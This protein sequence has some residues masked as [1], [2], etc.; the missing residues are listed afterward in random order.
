MNR[1]MIGGIIV[2]VV[3][4][5]IAGVFLLIE[6]PD[7]E[8]KTVFNPPLED[9]MQKVKDDLAAQKPQ[10][11]KLVVDAVKPPPGESHETG[12]WHDGHWHRTAL[13]TDLPQKLPV[14]VT[15]S[16]KTE[17]V[18]F[19]EVKG[20]N[21]PPPGHGYEFDESGKAT[22][23]KYNKPRFKTGWSEKFFPGQ[24][25]HK[26]SHDE[27]QLYH[28]LQHIVSGT[29]LRLDSDMIRLVKSGHPLPKAIYNQG[30]VEL[31]RVLKAELAEKA[32]GPNPRVGTDITWD[33]PFTP[34]ELAAI[35][36][37]EN[38]LLKSMRSPERPTPEWSHLVDTVIKD[39]EEDQRK[40]R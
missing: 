26:L 27:W 3:L 28:V 12:Y 18:K 32:S 29:V 31:A 2:L 22:L 21:A 15:E 38:E 40:R 37:Q 23:F 39:L 4:L 10:T 36:R 17:L 35:E 20:L 6:K 7:T 33:R 13:S 14:Y 8:P 9:D 11:E 25:F 16:D 24:D 19:W 30:V 1:N 34:E 5:G